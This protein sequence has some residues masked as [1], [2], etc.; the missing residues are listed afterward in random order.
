[1]SNTSASAPRARGHLSRAIGGL[2]L[3]LIALVAVG[4]GGTS[5]S[6]SP[7]T[8]AGSASAGPPQRGGALTFARAAEPTVL[9]PNSGNTDNPT[10]QT[11]I[12]LYDQ[13]L[14]L[15]PGSSA[16]RPGLA[17]S[18]S[19]SKDGLSWTFHLRHAR[20]SN[21][22]PVTSADVVFSL[23]RC[24]DP[25]VDGNFASTFATFMKSITAP[26]AHT[27]VIHLV[28]PDLGLPYWLTFNV[29]SIVSKV[30]MLRM[31]AQRYA[32]NPIGSGP[33]K[34]ASWRH[35]QELTLVRNPYYWRKG[36][37]YLDKVVMATVASDNTRVLQVQSGQADLADDLPFSQIPALSA[38]PSL[39][40]VTQP[41]GI[42]DAVAVN[43]K[44][45]PLDEVA[46][47]QALS[48]A[49][50][51]AAINHVVFKDRGQIANSVEPRVVYWSG[52]VKPYPY[53]VAKA[54]ALLAKSSVPHGFTIPLEIVGADEPSKQT[55]QILQ[56]AWGQIGVHVQVVQTD[57]ATAI[58]HVFQGDYETSLLPPSTWSEDIPS[59]DEFATNLATSFGEQVFGY[60]DA[61]FT[62][63]VERASSSRSE[64]QRSAL[65]AQAQQVLLD[66]PPMIPIVFTPARAAFRKHVHGFAYTP[67]NWWTLDSVWLGR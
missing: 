15:R 46:V 29:P 33:F 65:F 49:M 43:L 6:G 7:P 51:K 1:M 8:G 9:D 14:E 47:R 13:L 37:P 31:G 3:A 38:N 17:E 22:R 62:R 5:G 18:W 2:A 56:Q 20:F 10:I 19:Q 28:H 59:E 63:L 45:H 53:D 67:T 16:P 12:Q 57:A 66:D 11:D 30:D 48:Y 24:L 21:G 4:C 34:L 27:V 26:D 23:E 50:P 55:A 40:L 52:A 25:K 64:K 41:L 54:K 32:T 61:N 42:I 60:H 58:N 35:G 36:L 39:T 44:K